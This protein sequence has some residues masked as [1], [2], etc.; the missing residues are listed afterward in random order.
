M[1]TYKKKPVMTMRDFA[2]YA[3][4]NLFCEERIKKY[5]FEVEE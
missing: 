1:K 4:T 2:K 5:L 3:D